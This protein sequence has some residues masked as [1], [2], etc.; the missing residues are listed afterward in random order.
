MSGS[1]LVSLI[2]SNESSQVTF[3]VNDGGDEVTYCN[4]Y[5][6]SWHLAS[7]DIG[8]IDTSAN[9]T[10]R[11]SYTDGSGACIGLNFMRN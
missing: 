3:V 7:G 5:D 8:F 6:G 1:N 2:K 9:Y 4:S 11:Y 10:V